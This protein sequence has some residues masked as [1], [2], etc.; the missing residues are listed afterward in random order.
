[1][2][3]RK[4]R[5]EA[6]KVYKQALDGRAKEIRDELDVSIELVRKKL[7]AV[8]FDRKAE[9]KA[10]ADAA[11][12]KLAERVK[13]LAAVEADVQ[14][15]DVEDV[16]EWSEARFESELASATAAFEARQEAKRRRE[17]LDRRRSR[18]R[19]IGLTDD[20][21]PADEQLL[22]EPWFDEFWARAYE[23]HERRV[24]ELA[25]G[26]LRSERRLELRSLGYLAAPPDVDL[27]DDETW[28][29]V[30]ADAEAAAAAAEAKRK[31]DAAELE[32]LRAE[33]ADREAAEAAKREAD[34]AASAPKPA[35][36]AARALEPAAGAAATAH[37]GVPSAGAPIRGLAI[38]LEHTWKELRR[39]ELPEYDRQQAIVKGAVRQ[40]MALASEVEGRDG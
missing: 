21:M 8:E 11:R 35:T 10:I 30:R 39:P 26:E 13:A 19:G 7:E 37:V 14:V 2:D 4:A 22:D 20:D 18:L 32:K 29:E 6:A 28:A 9:E 36:E 25:R 40:L 16:E 31:A 5:G 15:E 38:A 24:A 23:A 34:E 17:L 12:R 33:K 27:A 1:E 3:E